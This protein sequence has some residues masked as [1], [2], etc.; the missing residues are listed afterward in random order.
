MSKFHHI[1]S[2][3]IRKVHFWGNSACCMDI[4]CFHTLSKSNLAVILWGQP[5]FYNH[6]FTRYGFCDFFAPPGLFPGYFQ[7]INRDPKYGTCFFWLSYSHIISLWRENESIWKCT[8][9][10]TQLLQYLLLILDS[11]LSDL[12]F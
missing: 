10:V 5:S 7:L 8:R 3:N 4:I 11:I 9:E 2:S 1:R 12:C 6:P